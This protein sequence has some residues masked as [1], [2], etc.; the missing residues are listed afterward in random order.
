MWSGVV[1]SL[2][3]NAKM[4]RKLILKFYV[5]Q[6]KLKLPSWQV[7]HMNHTWTQRKSSVVLGMSRSHLPMDHFCL[8]CRCEHAF[9]SHIALLQGA[10]QAGLPV[11]T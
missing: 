11:P 9:K 7:M 10:E 6:H 4:I 8:K 3:D 5:K 2:L 1:N